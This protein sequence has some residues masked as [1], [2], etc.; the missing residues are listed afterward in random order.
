LWLPDGG[1]GVMPSHRCQEC[2]HVDGAGVRKTQEI[3]GEQVEIMACPSCFSSRWV[4]DTAAQ[5]RWRHRDRWG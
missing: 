1:E 3:D 2:G 4:S 5:H